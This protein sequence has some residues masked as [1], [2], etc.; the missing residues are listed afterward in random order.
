MKFVLDLPFHRRANVW[1]GEPPPGNFTA[2]SVITKTIQPRVA[3][4]A[5]QTI[6]AVELYIPHGPKTSYALLG[7]EFTRTD[8]DGLQLIVCVN[9]IGFPS[10]GSIASKTDDVQIGL[11]EEYAAAVINGAATVAE[12]VGAPIGGELRFQ[13]SA[14]GLVG[15]SPSIFQRASAIVLRLLMMS[16]DCTD[17][18][19]RALIG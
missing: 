3:I 7:A 12:G 2:S 13:W 9:K 14:H 6:A 4:A 17:D 5:R 18:E 16:N 15:S 8:V 1:L 19:I 10:A 11:L